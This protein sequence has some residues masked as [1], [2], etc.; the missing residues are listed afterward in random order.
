MRTRLRYASA[1]ARLRRD[2]PTRQARRCY[3][4]QFLSHIHI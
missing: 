2:K 1:F 4:I 3:D